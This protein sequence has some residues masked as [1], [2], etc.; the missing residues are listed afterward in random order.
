MQAMARP[1]IRALMFKRCSQ[2]NW[3]V[4]CPGPTRSPIN[5]TA[6]GK[7]VINPEIQALEV[8]GREV[9]QLYAHSPECEESELRGKHGSKIAF[10]FMQ[11]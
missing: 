7:A 11:G 6:K 9:K 1:T 3:A 10:L 4:T 8:F 5:A 2:E